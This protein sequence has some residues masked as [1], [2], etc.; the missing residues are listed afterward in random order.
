MSK[1]QVYGESEAIFFAVVGMQ[2]VEES[3]DDFLKAVI[4][5]KLTLCHDPCIFCVFLLGSL[6]GLLPFRHLSSVPSIQSSAAF[7]H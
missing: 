1:S 3:H 6:F 5:D 7:T 2:A 4:P